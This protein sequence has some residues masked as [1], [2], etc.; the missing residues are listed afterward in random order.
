VKRKLKIWVR[1][2]STGSKNGKEEIVGNGGLGRV[3]R[4]I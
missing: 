2:Y 3:K 1:G 4:G